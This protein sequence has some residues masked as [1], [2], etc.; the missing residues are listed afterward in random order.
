MR[1]ITMA[2]ATTTSRCIGEVST[3]VCVVETSLAC[4]ARDDKRL[5]ARADPD[6]WKSISQNSP[7]HPGAHPVTTRYSILRAVRLDARTGSNVRSPH[8]A[9]SFPWRPGDV[10]VEVEWSSD[11]LPMPRREQHVVR[12]TGGR[13]VMVPGQVDVTATVPPHP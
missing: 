9:I 11:E 7:S 3:P 12:H 4:Y 8:P 5:C 2:D 6:T 13:W 1:V 10:L